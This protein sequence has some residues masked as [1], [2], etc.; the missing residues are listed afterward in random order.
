MQRFLRLIIWDALYCI[1]PT[2]GYAAISV[3][4]SPTVKYIV[5]LLVCVFGS[6]FLAQLSRWGAGWQEIVLIALP[7]L[8]IALA[9]F[10]APLLNAIPIPFDPVPAML[11]KEQTV[12]LRAAGALAAGFVL[13]QHTFLRAR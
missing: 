12:C 13:W 10:T 7:G 6:A 8:Y 2:V 5:I 4:T 11:L 3:L 9:P 1:V